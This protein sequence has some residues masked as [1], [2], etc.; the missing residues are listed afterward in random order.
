[1]RK[2]KERDA[3]LPSAPLAKNSRNLTVNRE[4]SFFMINDLI[5]KSREQGGFKE[6]QRFLE[7]TEWLPESFPV[8]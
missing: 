6:F 1:M 4:N 7:I 3:D 2:V 8:E 5:W